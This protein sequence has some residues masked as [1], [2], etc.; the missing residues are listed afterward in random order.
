MSDVRIER[1]LG[2][3]PALAFTALG[4]ILR[5]I[6]AQ[7]GGWEGFALHVDLGDA[8]LP[9]VGYVAIP[10]ALDVL[11]LQPGLQQVNVAIRAARHPESFPT[12][13]GAFGIDATGPTGA[14]LWSAGNY[15]VPL[16]VTGRL[17]DATVLR[18]I[19]RKALDNLLDDVAVACRARIEKREAAYARYRLFDRA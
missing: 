13:S 14:M 4:E 19:A 8:G 11:P 1:Q 2:A 18:G 16:Q 10:I 7:Q 6:A 9:D 17:I 15:E 12:F 5:D 3:P